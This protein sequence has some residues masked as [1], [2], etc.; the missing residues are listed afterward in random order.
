MIDTEYEQQILKD[1]AYVEE[2][3]ASATSLEDKLDLR[4]QQRVLFNKLKPYLTQKP[5]D[6]D[7]ECEGCGA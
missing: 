7:Y 1:L 4:D 2:L 6:S 5:E 3:L